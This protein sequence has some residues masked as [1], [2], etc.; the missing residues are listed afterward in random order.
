MAYRAWFR[1]PGRFAVARAPAGRRIPSPAAAARGS[2]L[3]RRGSRPDRARKYGFFGFS[4]SLRSI[5]MPAVSEQ[6]APVRN[7][8]FSGAR[9]IAPASSSTS[10]VVYFAIAILTRIFAEQGSIVARKPGGVYHLHPA[11]NPGARWRTNASPIS[12]NPANPAPAEKRRRRAVGVPQ[13]ARA[14]AGRQRR[15]TRQQVEH[16][17]RRAAQFRRGDIGDE[18]RQQALGEAHVQAPEHHA[19]RDAGHAAGRQGGVR[20]DQQDEAGGEHA[21]AVAPIGEGARRIGR[22]RIDDVHGDQ[23]QRRQRDRQSG[24]ARPQDRERPR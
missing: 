24:V 16:A 20:E 7:A 3:R 8:T 17:E 10:P 13:R 5:G 19:R 1:G 12:A 4:R 6:P 23:H 9:L 2:P 15:D 11:P 21:H 22:R 14:D 18:R